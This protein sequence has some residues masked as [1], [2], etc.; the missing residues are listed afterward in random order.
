MSLVRTFLFFYLCLSLTQGR[1]I[2]GS[3]KRDNYGGNEDTDSL[4]ETT[5]ASESNGDWKVL[6]ANG[7]IITGAG[8]PPTVLRLVGSEKASPGFFIFEKDI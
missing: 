6:F 7:T 2:K 8:K 3:R 5:N 4:D 1:Q